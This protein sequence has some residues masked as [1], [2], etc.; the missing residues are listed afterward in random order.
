MPNDRKLIYAKQ[1]SVSNN[2]LKYLMENSNPSRSVE[3]NHNK[4]SLYVAQKGQCKVTKQ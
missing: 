4:I 1:N 2:T 3:F